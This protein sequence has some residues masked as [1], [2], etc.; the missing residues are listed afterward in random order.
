MKVLHFAFSDPSNQY[1]PHNYLP[2]CIVYT[3]THDNDT[4]QGWLASLSEKEKRFARSYLD[5][6]D[7]D[8]SWPLI[9]LA[10][11]S[12]AE[13]CVVP[14]QDLLGLGSEARMNTPGTTAGNWRWRLPPSLLTPVVAQ[15][16]RGLTE[17]YGRTRPVS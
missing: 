6:A 12:V 3:G 4:T 17:T 2:N 16:L 5:L 9:R 7:E 8:V 1:L 15:H 14:L 10:L 13:M 11:S